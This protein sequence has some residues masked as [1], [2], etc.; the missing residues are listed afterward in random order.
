MTELVGEVEPQLAQG[1][2]EVERNRCLNESR[3]DSRL[4]RQS[5]HFG[6]PPGELAALGNQQLEGL[7]GDVVPRHSL[8]SSRLQ[9]QLQPPRIGVQRMGNEVS[10]QS[11]AGRAATARFE[12]VLRRVTRRRATSRVGYGIE[13]GTAPGRVL[14]P[15]G[16]PLHCLVALGR[17]H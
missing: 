7:C 3:P 17:R 4:V 16:E 14:Q 11:A 15:I 1:V 9:R 2:I 12:A 13:I 8:T 5:T 10:T 6:Q